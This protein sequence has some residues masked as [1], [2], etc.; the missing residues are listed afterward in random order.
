MNR[1]LPPPYSRRDFIKMLTVAGGGAALGLPALAAA[2]SGRHGMA[3]GAAGRGAARDWNWLVGSWDVWHRRL[4]ERL[5][6]DTRWEEFPG[7]SVLWLAMDGLGTIDDNVVDLPGGSY[8]GLTLRAFDPGTGQWSIWW[9][10]GRHPT[11][12]DPPVVGGFEGDVGTFFGRDTFKGRPITMRFRWQDIHGVRPWWEQAF[13]DD[14]GASWEINWRNYFTR[15]DAAPTPLPLL[16][17]APSD[18]DFLVGSWDVRHRRLRRRLVGSNDWDTFDGTLVNWPVLGGKGNVGD[19][20]M[21]LPSGTIRGIG[22]RSF[23]P[24]T[25]LWSSWWLDSR[26][27]STIAPPTRGG[28]ADGVGTFIGDD[29]LDGRPIKTRVVWSH[30]TARSARWEQ[31]SSADG[32]ATWEPNWISE[33]ARKT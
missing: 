25:R 7:R 4:K 5:V 11:R 9:L 26:T 19:N 6:G 20:V 24:G 17:D 18:F 15:T 33:L 27:P 16:A 29:T 23:D 31:S 22:L 21:N 8:R 14:G 2:R 3:G 28:F 10:D 32:G 1:H 13:S 30:I 12:I